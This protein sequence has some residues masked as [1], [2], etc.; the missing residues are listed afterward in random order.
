VTIRNTNDQG[1][2]AYAVATSGFVLFDNM[3]S[4]PT[5]NGFGVLGK[6]SFANGS[7]AANFYSGNIAA[8][9]SGF[10]QFSTPFTLDS[11]GFAGA[12]LDSRSASTK[13]SEK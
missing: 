6:M 7:I 10:Q 3:D 1:T 8:I 4:D 13:A 9:Q 11:T 12:F 5:N 2:G